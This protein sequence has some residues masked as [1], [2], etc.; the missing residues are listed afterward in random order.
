MA[1]MSA[2]DVIFDFLSAKAQSLEQQIKE[3]GELLDLFMTLQS[4]D[5]DNVVSDQLAMITTDLDILI[6][7]L[8]KIRQDSEFTVPST[9]GIIDRMGNIKAMKHE[10]LIEH[11][12]GKYTWQE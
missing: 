1:R 8:L 4:N 6:K 7:D 3:K 2:D 11:L 9:Q 12:K 5:P 10:N